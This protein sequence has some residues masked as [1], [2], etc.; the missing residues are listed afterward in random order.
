MHRSGRTRTAQ[1]GAGAN[2]LLLERESKAVEKGAA[3]FVGLGGG[4]DGDVHAALAVDGVEIDLGEDELL[5]HAHG[6]VAAAVEAIGRDTAEVADTGD[7]HSGEAVEE[8]PHAVAAQGDLG[9]DRH[10]G[11]QAEGRDGL[12]GAGR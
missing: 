5:G 6:E 10:A 7:R 1:P 8:L 3:L 12:A 11:A 9:A 2:E 4:D